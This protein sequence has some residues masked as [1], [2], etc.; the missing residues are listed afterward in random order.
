MFAS[1]TDAW[2]SDFGSAKANALRRKSIQDPLCELYAQSLQNAVE[3]YE[4]FEDHAPHDKNEY[5]CTA[6]KT[7]LKQLTISKGESI[8]D[9]YAAATDDEILEG[10]I[11]RAERPAREDKGYLDFLTFVASG[12]FLI[13]VLDLFFRM[14]KN[15]T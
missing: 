13:V 8:I 7:K 2:G 4:S 5:S 1:V 6:P 3:G 10:Y 11:D 14:G 9:A 15:R 12:V